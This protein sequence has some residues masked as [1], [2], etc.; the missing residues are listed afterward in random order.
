MRICTSKRKP[1]TTKMKEQHNKISLNF[2]AKTDWFLGQKP[3]DFTSIDFLKSRQIYCFF[4]FS[5]F[6]WN[7]FD[8]LFSILE[9]LVA[10]K[11]ISS[12]CLLI[13]GGPPCLSAFGAPVS[14]DKHRRHESSCRS[15]DHETEITKA[16]EKVRNN[17]LNM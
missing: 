11:F 17:T 8:W 3:I 15:W 16:T 14:L 5:C 6:D 2:G 12:I 13:F 1:K 7:K 10:Y 4:P 9:S